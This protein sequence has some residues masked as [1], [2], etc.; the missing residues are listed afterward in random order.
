MVDTNKLE[1]VK[2]STIAI[3]LAEENK[4]PRYILGTGFFVSSDASIMSAAHV[5]VGCAEAQQYRYE[6]YGEKLGIVAGI[7]FV[8]GGK[9]RTFSVRIGKQTMSKI[10]SYDLGYMG[11]Q[12]FDVAVAKLEEEG[13]KPL[14]F[15]D[16]HTTKPN[17]YEEVAMCGYPQGNVTFAFLSN[18]NPA[19]LRVSP[20]LQFGHVSGFM[21]Y[22]DANMDSDGHSRD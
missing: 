20:V 8:E 10:R 2:Q 12:D 5:F 7:A 11:P 19:G 22:D 1:K 18:P 14:A 16:L 3:D 17:L 21:P 9:F 13:S 15:L 4:F 6:K